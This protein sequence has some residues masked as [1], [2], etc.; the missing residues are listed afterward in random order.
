MNIHVCKKRAYTFLP[1]VK[2]IKCSRNCAQLNV[3]C[4]C[5]CVCVCLEINIGVYFSVHTF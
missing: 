4:V 2:S 1:D 5:V 3:F